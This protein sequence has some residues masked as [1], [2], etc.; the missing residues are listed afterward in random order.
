MTTPAGRA[1]AIDGGE[2]G[3]QV[4]ELCAADG[5]RLGARFFPAAE[6]ERG[7]LVVAAATAVPQGFYARFARYAAAR[8]FSTL[9]FDY[10][11]TGASRPDRLRGFAASFLDWAE[12]D[13]AAAVAAM[14]GGKGPV[15]VVGHSFGGQAYGL[16]PNPDQVQG[17]YTFGTGA[18]WHGWM[19]RLESLRVRALWHVVIP[20]LTR[21]RGYLPMSWAGMG[22]DLP[23]GVARQWRRWCSFPR[24]FFDDPELADAMHARFSAVRT[25]VVAANALD[26]RWIPPPARE[27]FMAGYQQAPYRAVDIDPAPYGGLGHMGYFRARAEPLWCDVIDWAGALAGDAR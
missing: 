26:D 17:L 25:P 13:L 27:A 23:L 5:Y 9:T 12:L 16:L 6:H 1:T 8:G 21:S 14:Q 22:E 10:R 4:R 20:V 19:P 2:V 15:L 18:G 24:Y 11:G 3:G 7:R